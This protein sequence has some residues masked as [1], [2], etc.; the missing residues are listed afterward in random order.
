MSWQIGV[1]KNTLRMSTVVAER[2]ITVA[3][4]NN[5]RISYSEKDGLSLDPD[6]MEWMDFFWDDWAIDALNDPSVNGDV[7]FLCAEGDQAG[8]IWGYRFKHGHMAKLSAEVRL[9]ETE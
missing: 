4:A 7:V 8:Q 9:Q 1:Y 6:A 3:G 2:L 5:H